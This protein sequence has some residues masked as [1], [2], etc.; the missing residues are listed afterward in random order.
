MTLLAS[1]LREL[2]NPSLSPNQ[3]AQLRCE[4][5]R[6]LED[7]GEYEAARDVIGE[8]WISRALKG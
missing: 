2:E 7:T 6:R 3:R 5:A 4:A 8:L 1:V